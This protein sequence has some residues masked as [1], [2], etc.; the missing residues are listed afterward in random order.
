MLSFRITHEEAG[1]QARVGVLTTGRSEVATPA[2]M[3]V[4]SLG[5]VRSVDGEEL[6]KMGYGL[7]LNNAYHLY[8][9]PGH[10]VVEELGGVHGFT[11]WPGA[12]LTDSGGFQVFSL[13]KFCKVTDEGVVFQSHIDGSSRFISPETSIEI[14]E[15]LGAD[16]IM[17]FDHVVAL[18]SSLDQV[19][20]AAKRTSLWARRCV[21]AK[22]RTDQSLFGIVQ[23]GLDQGLRVESARD[24]VSVGF[25]GYA[26]GGLSVGEDKA[27]MYAMLDVTV[28]ELP[29]AKPRYLMG[30]GMPE[31]L[32][33]GVARGIDMFDCVV[34]SR[35]GRTGWLFTSF[36]RVVIKQAR[37]A[38]D[39]Q[40]ID[41]ACRCPVCTRY[42]RAYLHH[43]FGVKEMLG[44]R[45]NKIH[46]LW[47]FAKLMEEIRSAVRNGTF[48]EFRREFHRT[49]VVD[50]P[51][52]DG[53]SDIDNTN[54]S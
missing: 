16:I 46:N 20:A 42:T 51:G 28:P 38:R 22:R 48:Q 25:D 10:K 29:S 44:A 13:A 26:V 32:V 3:P 23:G 40:P 24:L 15:A 6:L 39:E 9:R 12:I 34:P 53:R 17:A 5:N 7:I 47:F 41:P 35:H 33:E 8:L 14:Q 31:D 4:G 52:G 21:E 11:A 37:Y 30:V 2:F 19:R 36:G 43:L 27:D 18:P 54:M 45:L 49:Y 50:R 1:G